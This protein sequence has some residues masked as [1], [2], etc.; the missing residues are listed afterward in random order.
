MPVFYEKQQHVVI[1]LETNED[2][3]KFYRIC[4]GFLSQSDFSKIYDYL[5]NFRV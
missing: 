4:E 1:Q 3:G 5:L 2:W